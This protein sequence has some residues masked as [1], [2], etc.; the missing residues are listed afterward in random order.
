MQDISPRTSLTWR[1]GEVQEIKTVGD[2]DKA[3]LLV[4]VIADEEEHYVPEH[5]CYLINARTEADLVS[6][7]GAQPPYKHIAKRFFSNLSSCVVTDSA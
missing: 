5:E 2:E 4:T 6:R 3:Q 7:I 1:I